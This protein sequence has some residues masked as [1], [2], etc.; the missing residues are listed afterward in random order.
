[1]TEEDTSDKAHMEAYQS[2]MKQLYHL[3]KFAFVDTEGLIYT[4]TGTQNDIE[5]YS[6]DYRALSEPEISIFN[7]EARK[8]A[9]LSRCRSTFSLKGK[10]CPYALWK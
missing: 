7:P 4:S 1:M 3:D 9:S 5:K 6:F 8:N 10:R 2:R